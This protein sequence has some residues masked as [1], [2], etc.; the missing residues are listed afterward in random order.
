ML[1]RIATPAH[2]VRLYRSARMRPTLRLV[3]R[4]EPPVQGAALHAKGLPTDSNC[5]MLGTAAGA[6]QCGPGRSPTSRFTCITCAR[7]ARYFT[8]LQQ[9][10]ADRRRGLWG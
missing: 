9:R 2:D 8:Q 7:A 3:P 6:C 1:L 4:T 5:S 10:N